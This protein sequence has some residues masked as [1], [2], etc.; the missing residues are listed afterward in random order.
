MIIRASLNNSHVS[1]ESA[2]TTVPK[3][4]NFIMQMYLA[5]RSEIFMHT[6]DRTDTVGL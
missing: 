1:F 6:Y 3:Q 5:L 2:A 4:S